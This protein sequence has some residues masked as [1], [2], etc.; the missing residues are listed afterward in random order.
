MT[1]GFSSSSSCRRGRALFLVSALVLAG[2]ASAQEAAKE[3]WIGD[4]IGFEKPVMTHVGRLPVVG[5]DE[6]AVADDLTAAPAEL[7]QAL[8]LKKSRR[9]E[10]PSAN[11]GLVMVDA[12]T[13]DV[14]HFEAPRA[15]F[16]ALHQEMV[17][18][19][20]TGPSA[21]FADDSLV[22]ETEEEQ[23]GI[24]V[25]E[26]WS[27]GIPNFIRR[28]VEDGVATNHSVYRRI[29]QI[30]SGC[31][32][33][34]V[35]ARHVLTA[36]HCAVNN[37]TMEVYSS[38]FRPRRDGSDTMAPPIAPFGARS[39]ICY[40]FP[41]E[42]WNGTCNFLSTSDCN[43]YDIALGILDSS[44]T[45]TPSM[46]YAV[47]TL[48]SLNSLTKWNRG[49]PRCE[50]DDT[51]DA[52]APGGEDCTKFTLYGDRASCTIGAVSSP[53]SDGYNREL[54]VDCDGARGMSGSPMYTTESSLGLVALGVYS[55]FVC[56][57]GACATHPQGEYPNT[58]TRITPQYAAMISAAK[59]IWSCSSGICP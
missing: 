8:T 21:D 39:F 57:A 24:L 48:A 20:E 10:T 37:I 43:K 40:I 59:A 25:T 56:T 46:G 1:R 34:L 9:T 18:R 13:G 38:S 58:Y 35:G 3:R 16:E 2:G 4:S 28:G 12:V 19:G 15:A 5:L 52:E 29:G 7:R 49:Y 23:T 53:D 36:A 6:R 30:G 47:Y 41:Q 14:Y 50:V 32:G 11:M 44:F 22:P 33:A 51:P 55:Q 42:Y 31:S 54:W 45:N 26:S 17:R 27:D